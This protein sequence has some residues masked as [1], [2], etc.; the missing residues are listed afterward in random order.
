VTDRDWTNPEEILSARVLG[1]V[2]PCT[3]GREHRVRTREVAIEYG[4]AYRIPEILPDVIPGRRVLLVAD[5][6]T[7]EAAGNQLASALAST[8]SVELCRLPE[9]ASGHIH[10]S[11]ELADELDGSFPARYDLIAAVGSGTVN[12]LAK[13]LAHRRSIPYFVLATA[14]SMNGYTSAIVALLDKGLKTTRATTPPVAVFADPQILVDAPHELTLAGLGDLV[15]KPFC[16]CDWKIASL[17]KGEYYCPMPN[18]LLSEPF[19]NALDLFPRLAEDDPAAVTELFRLLLV[20]G[21]S[22]SITG[23]SSPASG[24]E[25]LISHYWDMTRLRD[26]LPI[27]LHGA[28]VGVGSLLMDELY[29][30]IS[31]RDFSSA[32]FEPNPS[33]ES[34]SEEIGR[35]F[36]SLAD[37]VW[38]QWNTKLD[39]R[40]AADLECIVEH[41]VVI[42]EEIQATLD[43]GRKVRRALIESGAPTSAEQLRVSA[44]ESDAAIRHGRKIRTRFTV[45]DVAAELGILGSFAD[46]VRDRGRS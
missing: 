8:H 20:S 17:V 23:T 7:L 42:K 33:L 6:N 38:P 21:I 26:G 11:V 10:A 46:R 15:S 28:Q 9:D 24:G 2:L 3:C 36:G 37:A 14:A 12:D 32:D 5:K 29:R 44:S 27:N 19:E 34:A 43:T 45:L 16:G 31:D 41:Q 13:E 22:M 40:S 35:I 39:E 4:V 25:H 18:R 1:T 30:E